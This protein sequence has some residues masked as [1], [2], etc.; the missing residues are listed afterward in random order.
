MASVYGVEVSNGKRVI[1]AD[2]IAGVF[3][4]RRN[5]SQLND[6]DDVIAVDHQLELVQYS[7]KVS[8]SA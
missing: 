1:I 6:C 4:N 2:I 8:I 5:F 7:K 3:K